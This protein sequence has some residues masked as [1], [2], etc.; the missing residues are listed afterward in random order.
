MN[1]GDYQTFLN[2]D[3]PMFVCLIPYFYTTFIFIS[4]VA[5]NKKDFTN[6]TISTG[7]TAEDS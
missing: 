7:G 4:K 6:K 5:R 1:N 3:C 2:R